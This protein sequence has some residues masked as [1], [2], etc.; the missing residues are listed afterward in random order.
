[1]KLQFLGKV[2]R[3]SGVGRFFLTSLLLLALLLPELRA[4][5]F[6]FK[7]KAH[8]KIEPSSKVHIPSKSKLTRGGISEWQ[9]D[10]IIRKR[11]KKALKLGRVEA[12]A[13]AK[14]SSPPTAHAK[15]KGKIVEVNP[16]DVAF[17]QRTV[18]KSFDTPD[19]KVSI[20]STIRKG[21]AQVADFPPLPAIKVKGKWVVRDGNSRLFVGRKTKAKTIKLEDVGGDTPSWVDFNKR[22][23][24]NGLGSQ[25][26]KKLP[27]PK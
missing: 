27:T 5:R 25:G 14:A 4:A 10:R 11:H 6:R 3:G 24:Q 16:K 20:H 26:T 7:P 15:P 1:M 9:A 17:S 22:L 21:P 8:F 18:N 19:G 12:K 2:F 23:S 13:K